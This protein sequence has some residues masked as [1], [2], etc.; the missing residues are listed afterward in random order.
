MRLIFLLALWTIISPIPSSFTRQKNSIQ[1]IQRKVIVN[2]RYQI[3]VGRGVSIPD[4]LHTLALVSMTKT[5]SVIFCVVGVL[6]VLL[7]VSEEI[8]EV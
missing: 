3:H 1:L 8:L 7:K 4:L 6:S 5:T 2:Q